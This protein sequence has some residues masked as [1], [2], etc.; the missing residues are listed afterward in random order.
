MPAHSQEQGEPYFPDFQYQQQQQQQQQ[1]QRLLP[2]PLGHPAQQQHPAEMHNGNGASSPPHSHPEPPSAGAVSTG[3]RSGAAESQGRKAEPGSKSKKGKEKEKEKDDG[4]GSAADKRHRPCSNCVNRRIPHLCR[5]F[6]PAT[7]SSDVATRLSRLE[8]MVGDYLP[9]ILDRLDGPR[10]GMSTRFDMGPR[11]HPNFHAP[12]E[13][14]DEATR[15]SFGPTGMYIGSSTNVY[16]V[17]TVLEDVPPQEIPAAA[18]HVTINATGAEQDLDSVLSEFG[19]PA[20]GTTLSPSAMLV[21]ALPHRSTCD[22]LLDHFYKDLNWL[23]HPLPQRSLREAFDLFFDSGPKLT[24]DNLNIFAILALIC[25]IA[26]LSIDSSVFTGRQHS[27]IVATRRLQWAARQALAMSTATGRGDLDA[28]LAWHLLCRVLLLERRQEEACLASGSSVKLAQAIGLHRDG[29]KLKIEPAETE[30]RRR[31]WA[32]IFTT[33][34]YLSWFTGRPASLQ[35][36]AIDSLPPNEDDEDGDICPI[37]VPRPPD[38]PT[39]TGMTVHRYRFALGS[40]F[41][42]ICELQQS[43]RPVSYNEVLAIDRELLE[44]RDA[45]PSYFK[46]PLGPTGAIEM[47]TSFDEYYPFLAPQRY[48]LESDFDQSRICLHRSYLL[49]SRNK[50]GS[51]YLPSRRACVEAAHHDIL[52]RSA[53]VASMKEKFDKPFI[54][55]WNV[56]YHSTKHFSS[57]AICGIALLS[58]PSSAQAATLRGH[59]VHFLEIAK[60]KEQH[61]PDSPFLEMYQRE[62]SIIRLFLEKADELA[63]APVRAKV[64]S[65]EESATARKRS[66]TDDSPQESSKRTRASSDRRDESAS[67]SHDGEE[68]A[69]ANVLLGLGQSQNPGSSANATPGSTLSNGKSPV[70]DDAQNILDAWFQG[71][72]Q[73]P[74]ND[75]LDFALGGLTATELASLPSFPSVATAGPLFGGAGIGM[76]NY[77]TVAAQGLGTGPAVASMSTS[78]PSSLP[79]TQTTGPMAAAQYAGRGPE[80]NSAVPGQAGP[81]W[82]AAAQRNETTDMSQFQGYW[83][84]LID[85]ISYLGVAFDRNDALL[86][87]TRCYPTQQKISTNDAARSH[88]ITINMPVSGFADAPL[89]KGLLIVTCL[90]PLFANLLQLKPY[91][92]FQLVPHVL[93]QGQYWRLVTFPLCY[94]NSSEVLLSALL[95]YRSGRTVERIFG[96]PKY[97]AFLLLTLVLQ[98][99]IVTGCMLAALRAPSDGWLVFLLPAVW[100]KQGRL[101]GGP[102]GL[103]AALAHQHAQ[104]VPDLWLVKMGPALVGD[105]ALDWVLLAILSISQAEGSFLLCAAGVITSVLYASRLPGLKALRR[106]RLPSILYRV[107]G[108]IGTPW[109]GSTRMPQRSSR[110]EPRRRRTR[111]Q[112][113]AE[114]VLREG[115]PPAAGTPAGGGAGG[116]AAGTGVGGD[117]ANENNGSNQ[118]TVRFLA[119]LV[120]RW[121][122]RPTA[123]PTPAAG[124]DGAPP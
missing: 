63:A 118:A 25:S 30:R 51:R 4:N 73:Q 53:L 96:T 70:A 108:K 47:D 61:S 86:I 40:F 75:M 60:L 44:W 79:T 5:T 8:K 22:L 1:Q 10:S 19:W 36:D 41:L 39:I 74:A 42:R 93:R 101:P 68:H 35:Q 94:T 27:R 11:Q 116:G 77:N 29:V 100:R 71:G 109:I 21:A 54:N 112:R 76:P 58:D 24:A 113:N 15:G 62:A 2:P 31:L 85:K 88:P 7:D 59:L 72:Y 66:L 120:R 119:G 111:A 49:L 26:S 14:V 16:A 17:G 34:C 23:R 124:A 38:V 52:H 123:A 92:H 117:S 115:P 110:A 104:L 48:L 82:L 81:S 90:L 114:R 97:A 12:E 87:A 6:D 65:I 83:E 33:E 64:R 122:R 45:L 32:I 95:M 3:S 56:H 78:Y 67:Q 121:S 107:L 37:T 55:I 102:F 20:L 57:V 91:A 43:L 69:T 28:V 18:G 103:V 46:C 80:T 106:I 84:T 9:A 98:A 105:R 13:D 99:A 50:G 89:T